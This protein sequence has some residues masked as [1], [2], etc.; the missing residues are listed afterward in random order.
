MS[1]RRISRGWSALFGVRRRSRRT[2]CCWGLCC[3]LMLLVVSEDA[4]ATTVAWTVL[5]KHTPTL[6]LWLGQS[7]PS[8]N[9]HCGLDNPVQAHLVNEDA[10]A[11]TPRMASHLP[12][13]RRDADAT[14]AG[15]VGADANATTPRMALHQC[16]SSAGRRRYE[17]EVRRRGRCRYD[18]KNGVAPAS[19]SAGRRRYE[20]EVRRWGR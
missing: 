9:A 18:A 2:V 8:A 5:S 10:D 7:C 13:R 15:C 12:R 14:N 20:C 6:Q 17:C 11:T 1:P 16:C 4:N 3:L 19:S